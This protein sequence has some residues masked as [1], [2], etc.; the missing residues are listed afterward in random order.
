MLELAIDLQIAQTADGGFALGDVQRNVGPA[1]SHD[2]G[3]ALTNHFLEGF[4]ANDA[5]AAHTFG[6]RPGSAT[7]FVDQA[8]GRR[9]TNGL[10]DVQELLGQKLFHLVNSHS[11]G[12]PWRLAS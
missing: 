11:V 1:L 7:E 10:G 12:L 3:S 6:H 8:L 9:Q 5:E 2:G 4:V